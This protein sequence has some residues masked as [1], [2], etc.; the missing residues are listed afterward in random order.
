MLQGLPGVGPGRAQL[1][2]DHFGSVE[3]IL[4]A[5]TEELA[6]VHGIGKRTAHG[7]RWLVT[8]PGVAD[9]KP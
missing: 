2:L 6:A 7:I 4:T 5:A 9:Y 8:E 1:L 3:A